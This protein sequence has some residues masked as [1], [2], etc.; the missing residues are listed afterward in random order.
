M[1]TLQELSG[2][3]HAAYNEQE[4]RRDII[5]AE[6]EKMKEQAKRYQRIAAQKMGEYYKLY[7]K[8]SAEW[9]IGWTDG[10]LR[11]LLVE[12]EERT[13]WEFDD[14][15]D[16]RTYGLR[17]ECPVFIIG[18]GTD[19]LGYRNTKAHITFTVSLEHRDDGTWFWELWYDTGEYVKSY[20]DGSIGALN[21]FGKKTAKVESVEQVIEFLRKQMEEESNG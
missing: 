3:F 20:P 19:E 14:K 18:E 9:K 8:A 6:A 12:I 2:G 15:D 5:K 16:L 11:P 7:D 4:R 21:G 13:G 10:L 1:K 17:A